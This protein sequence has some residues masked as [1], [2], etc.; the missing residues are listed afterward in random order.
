MKM[1]R[2]VPKLLNSIFV[3][4]L[5]LASVSAQESALSSKSENWTRFRG[6]NGSGVVADAKLPTKWESSDYQWKSKLSGTGSSSPVV[7]KDKIYLT[8]C[9]S[10]TGELFLHCLG[11]KDGKEIWTKTF[12]S[13][14]YRVHSRNS[15]ASSTPA[16]DELG[17][18]VTFASPDR[19]VLAGIDHD[20]KEMWKRDFGTWISQHGYG[21]SPIVYENKVILVDSQQAQQIRR[22]QTPGESRVIAVDHQ[23]GKD[24]WTTPLTT[25][26]ACYAVPCIYKTDGKTQLIGCNTGEGFYSIDPDTGKMNWKHDAFKL[27]TV[28]SPIVAGNLLVGSCGTGGGN[29]NI[30]VAVEPGK[31]GVTK[32]FDLRSNSNYVPSP[33]A[34]DNLLFAFSDRGI[35]TCMDAENGSVHWRERVSAGFSGSPVANSEH[36]YCIDEKGVVVVIKANKEFSLVA[37]NSLG[38]SSRATPAI[39]DDGLLLRTESHLIRVNANT[40]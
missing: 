15:F 14:P 8:S 19:T 10:R 24:I 34:V 37:K 17:V 3:F 36:V 6:P 32:R 16:V 13:A 21:A 29:G 23:T 31:Q 7:W 40:K 26:K 39:V 30:M 18:F 22:G 9:D 35:V 2:F 38:E 33:I 20:G 4:P 11:K 5:F 28:A 12:E 27:R 1:K 25:T